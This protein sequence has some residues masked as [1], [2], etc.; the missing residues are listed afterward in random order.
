MSSLSESREGNS[1]VT[2]RVEPHGCDHQSNSNRGSNS[3]DFSFG[4]DQA[5]QVIRMRRIEH[6]FLAVHIPLPH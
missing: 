5:Q 1:Y 6:R 4:S 2:G 3:L